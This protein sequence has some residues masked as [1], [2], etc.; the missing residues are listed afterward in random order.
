MAFSSS[1]TTRI[2]AT[3]YPDMQTIMH[4]LDAAIDTPEPLIVTLLGKAGTGKTGLHEY[5]AGSYRQ[6]VRG[7]AIDRQPVLVAEISAPEKAALG[8]SVY[9][10]PIACVTFSVLMYALRELSRQ[11]DPPHPALVS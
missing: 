11:V 5:W 10:T 4:A 9:T 7:I 6:Q 2:P 1:S 3:R 8:R